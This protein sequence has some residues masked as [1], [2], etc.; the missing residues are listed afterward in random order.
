MKASDLLEKAGSL[1]FDAVACAD[2]PG[3]K[4]HL[5]QAARFFFFFSFFPVNR[6][7]IFAFLVIRIQ[8]LKNKSKT[9][10]AREGK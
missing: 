5:L 2:V 7:S 1:D 4:G 8:S 6:R 10:M 3:M 9:L